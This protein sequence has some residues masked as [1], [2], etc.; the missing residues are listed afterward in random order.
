[1]SVARPVWGS[2]CTLIS[3]LLAMRPVLYVL[4]IAQNTLTLMELSRRCYSYSS[5]LLS[6]VKHARGG[7]NMRGGVKC[8]M[9]NKL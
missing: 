1:M 9:G 6:N 2:S 3:P 8:P 4:I 5:W 7:A